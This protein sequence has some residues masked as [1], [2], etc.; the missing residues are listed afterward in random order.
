MVTLVG[1]VPGIVDTRAHFFNPRTP[2]WSLQRIGRVTSPLLRALPTPLVR[3]AANFT[4][5]HSI[6]STACAGAL[7]RRYELS[8]YRNDLAGLQSVAGV[9]VTSVI[10]V[11]SQWRRRV[12]PEATMGAIERDL[13]WLRRQPYGQDGAPT[14]GGL[15]IPL[16]ER[17][18]GL[19]IGELLEADDGLIRGVRLRWGRHPDPLVHNW[20]PTPEAIASATIEAAM[21]DLIKRGLVIESL[22]YSTQLGELS[23]LV[24]RFPEATFIVEHLGLPAGVFGPIGSSAGSTAAAR[25]DILS[26]WRERMSMLAAEPNVLVKISGIGSALLGYGQQKAGN[27]GGQHI[28]ADMI[29]P[30]VLHVVD[31]FGPGRVMFGSNAPLDD[32]NASIGVTVGALLDVLSDRGDYLLAHF[33]HDNAKRV[34]RIGSAP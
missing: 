14:L 30:L 29:G 22:C 18:A 12:S 11:D 9:P 4:Q 16:D 7:T 20:T 34:Y 10:P 31:R 32:C 19:G 5:E 8:D 24:H 6:T 25:A 3:L 27:I 28:L 23:A 15:V 13:D 21:P 17:I 1:K 2:P 33:F 26:L